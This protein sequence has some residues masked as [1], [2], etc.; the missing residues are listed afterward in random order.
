MEG[1]ANRDTKSSGADFSKPNRIIA[2]DFGILRF[3]VNVI[4]KCLLSARITDLVDK[5]AYISHIFFS[6]SMGILVIQWV[7]FYGKFNYVL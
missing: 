5:I 6:H 3:G 4:R 1:Y 7:F 2:V